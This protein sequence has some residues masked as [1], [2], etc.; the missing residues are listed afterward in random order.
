MVRL[1][2]AEVTPLQDE[3]YRQDYIEC[4]SQN[5]RKVGVQI[6]SSFSLCVTW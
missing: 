2:S 1:P 3:V 4:V 6:R 5:A